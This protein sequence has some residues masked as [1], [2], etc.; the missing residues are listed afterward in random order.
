M[1]LGAF[2]LDFQP[3]CFL[4]SPSFLRF[5][6]F[7]RSFFI[8]L[9]FIQCLLEGKLSPKVTDEVGTLQAALGLRMVR[10]PSAR[11]PLRGCCHRR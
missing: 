5:S 3:A 8:Q 11:F 2:G 7:H 10:S 9:P 6:H 4:F 1:P